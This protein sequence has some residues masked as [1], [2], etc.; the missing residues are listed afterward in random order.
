MTEKETIFWNE[1][2]AEEVIQRNKKEYTVSGQWT[3]SGYFHIGNARP[4]IFTPYAVKLALEKK[5]V[6]KYVKILSLMILMWYEKSQR[7][8]EYRKTR[9]IYTWDSL[10]LPLLP[11]LPGFKNWADIFTSQLKEYAPKFGFELNFIS[12]HE[13]YKDG[14]FNE[15]IRFSIEH[16]TEITEVWKRVSG[17]EKDP[18][19]VPI[20]I[21][22]PDTGKFITPKII[23]FD[24]KIIE[25]N[26]EDGL[27][28]KISPYN[29]NAKL[30]WRVHWVANWI[31]NEVDFESAGKDHFSKGGSVDVG[32]ALMKEVFHKQPPRTSTH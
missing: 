4:E 7:T 23:N 15:L 18:E 14:T 27:P 16:P 25:Y 31:V 19:F 9:K 22:S 3:P 2:V 13:M 20:Q 29:G 12:A 28:T 8:L 32:Q 17:S 1:K 10:A 6:P 21:V 26:N 11:P 24:G 5:K 30:H